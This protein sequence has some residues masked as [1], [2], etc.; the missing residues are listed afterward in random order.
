M[1]T[2]LVVVLLTAC[3]SGP[4]P[5]APDESHRVAVNRV[6]PPEATTDELAEKPARKEKA[7]IEWR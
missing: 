4:M 7:H 6:V 5:K 1:K 3:A 2:A